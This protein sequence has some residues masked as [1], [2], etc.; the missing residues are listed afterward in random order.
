MKD[1]FFNIHRDHKFWC[2]KNTKTG[3]Y[4][5]YFFRWF[6]AI[7]EIKLLQNEKITRVQVIES[8]DYQKKINPDRKNYF[9]I[10]NWVKDRYKLIF[11]KK[12]IDIIRNIKLK[13]DE[14]IKEIIIKEV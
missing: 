3:D 4:R 9:A 8:S 14:I 7:S 6:P 12:R 13:I 11:Y 2:I 1:V 5:L 10:Y